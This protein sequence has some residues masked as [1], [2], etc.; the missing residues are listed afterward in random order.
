MEMLE[1]KDP[2]W[3]TVQ[4]EEEEEEEEEIFLDLVNIGLK[5]GQACS[6]SLEVR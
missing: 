4:E 3:I 6:L 5:P 2:F 1:K